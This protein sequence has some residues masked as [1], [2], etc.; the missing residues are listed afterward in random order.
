MTRRAD[1][2]FGGAFRVADARELGVSAGRL[3]ARGLVAPARGS[4]VPVGGSLLEAI[5][6]LLGPGQAFTG[7]TAARLWSMPIP[8]RWEQ[9][10]RVWVSALSRTHGMQRPGVISSRRS[11]GSVHHVQ[12][13]PVLGPSRTWASLA[14]L[15]E[16]HDLVAVADRLI[17][18]SPRLASLATIDELRAEVDATRVGA[19]A[20]RAA[21]AE[22][23][24]GAWSRPETLLRLALTRAGVPEPV[25][26][27]AVD[28]DGHRTAAPDLAWPEY[29]VCAEYDGT[30]HDE[31]RVRAHDLERQELLADAGWLVV[32]IRAADLFPEPLSAVARILRR[33][34]ERGY[35]HPASI[36]SGCRAG[37]LP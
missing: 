5:A 22:V 16:V 8:R 6:V 24:Q 1:L 2:P 13:Y 28:V 14:R 34:T 11:S 10:G 15:L 30:W 35:R 12:G 26:N 27:V 21:L 20:L 31:P 3:R 37:W 36:R 19:P 4:R 17:T 33:L 7:P 25:L 23:R 32:R 18:D 29:L 9:D